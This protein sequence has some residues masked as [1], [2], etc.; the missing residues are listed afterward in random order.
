MGNVNSRWRSAREALNLRQNDIAEK[1]GI[2]QGSA[3]LYEKNGTIPLSSIKSFSAICGV[4]ESYLLNGDLPILEPPREQTPVQRIVE[5]LNLPPICAAALE[6]WILMPESEQEIIKRRIQ[7]T[8]DR[9]NAQH[10]PDDAE[11]SQ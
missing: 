11:K 1:L 3:S 5:E 2:S 6:E 10:P 8:I 7:A 4:R 9:H